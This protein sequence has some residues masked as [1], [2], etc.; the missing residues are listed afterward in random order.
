MVYKLP[1][2]VIVHVPA[3]DGTEHPQWE[4]V[5][6]NFKKMFTFYETASLK[7]SLGV[8]QTPALVYY[9]K[10]VAKKKVQ[11][12]VFPPRTSFEEIHKEIY[13]M[14][15]DFTVALAD[16]IEMQK[17]TGIHLQDGKY[18]AV[19]FHETD[20]PLPYKLISNDDLFEEE[21]AFFRMKNPEPQVL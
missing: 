18:V 4:T 17:H 8:K 1:E 9:P 3:A 14:I 11:K 6:K 7:D 19:L 12:T 15:D 2:Y 13:E 21:V 10:S 5:Q 20:I 16:G